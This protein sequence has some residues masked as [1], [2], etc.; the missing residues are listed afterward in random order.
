MLDAKLHIHQIQPNYKITIHFEGD[1][2]NDTDIS[3]SGN[4]YLLRTAFINLLENGCKFSKNK[5]SKVSINFDASD[6]LLKFED[7]G[8]GITEEDLENIFMP[9]Y[10]GTNKTYADGNGIGL[11]LTQKI[12]QLHSGS[13]TATSELSKGTIFSIRLKN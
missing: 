1:I 6:I 10:R 8:I 2:E 4:K 9:F 11:P 12:I 13:A 5:E 3:I 7:H